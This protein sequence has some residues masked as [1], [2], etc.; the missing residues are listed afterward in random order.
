MSK[1][2]NEYA[3]K[4]LIHQLSNLY[5]KYTILC[6]T[7]FGIDDECGSFM[8]S[9]NVSAMELFR[10]LDDDFGKVFKEIRK[11][12]RHFSDDGE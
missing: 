8:R 5:N 6:S 7:N 3:L 12:E 1:E 9:M 2:M 4:P 11:L 10:L